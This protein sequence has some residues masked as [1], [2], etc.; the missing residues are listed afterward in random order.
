MTLTTDYALTV[1]ITMLTVV[2]PLGLI[3]IYLP[4]ARRFSRQEQKQLV[5]TSLAIAVAVS[6]LFLFVGKWLFS[7]LGISYEALFVVGGILLFIIGLDMIYS[8]PRKDNTSQ[9]DAPTQ[10]DLKSMAVFPLAI[11][12]LSGPGTLAAIV[13]FVSRSDTAANY[14]L[15]LS[16]MIFAFLVAA[17]AMHFS[18][19]L[20]RLFGEVGLN[21]IDRVVGIVLCAL[22]V[23]FIINALNT[24][25]PQWLK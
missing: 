3:P 19:R 18:R 20:L 10:L 4:I 15:V 22:A 11:P 9:S 24:L 16:A 6:T 13:M 2:D 7:Y 5:L 8:R 1:F 12:M 25:I 14:A 23:Q 17:L 21:V